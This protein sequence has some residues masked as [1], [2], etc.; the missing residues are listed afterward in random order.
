MGTSRAAA[1]LGVAAV[2]AF[3]AATPGAGAPPVPPAAPVLRCGD[4][5]SSAVVIV[6]GKQTPVRFR[7]RP[8][9]DTLFGPLAF[10]GAKDYGP[11]ASWQAMVQQDGWL[12]TIALVQPG[13][14]VTI[15]VPAEQRGWMRLRYW[16]G[17][18]AGAYAVTIQACKR[19]LSPYSG[20]FAIDFAKAP[21]QGRCA[22]VVVW[23]RGR[24]QPLR[25]RI[26]RP[27]SACP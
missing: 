9:H 18:G 4:R 6:G 5:I 13:A 21:H 2:T 17:T 27:G 16:H 14:R 11:V 12:K 3:V 20:G 24:E 15:V 19:A 26:F 1:V 10:S 8:A 22:E 25:K 23:V 7:V